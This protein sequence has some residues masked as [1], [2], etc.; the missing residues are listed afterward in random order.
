MFVQPLE[1]KVVLNSGTL[2][3]VVLQGK[4]RE[5]GTTKTEPCT[6]IKGSSLR[7]ESFGDFRQAFCLW[8]VS[9]GRNMPVRDCGL[10]CF[11][12][13]AKAVACQNLAVPSHTFPVI[14][15]EF[16]LQNMRTTSGRGGGV[17]KH[18]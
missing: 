9:K 4:P 6:I 15:R 17:L 14:L 16:S 12:D 5:E 11:L 3:C 10:W 1:S 13:L 8:Q 2:L 18:G 7:V